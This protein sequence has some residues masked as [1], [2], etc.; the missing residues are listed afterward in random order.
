[1]PCRMDTCSLTKISFQPHKDL[2][3]QLDENILR[4]LYIALTLWAVLFSDNNN[5]IVLVSQ[6][7]PSQQ[8]LNSSRLNTTVCSYGLYHFL[9]YPQSQK[10]QVF[11]S[12]TK[13]FILF[14]NIYGQ[15]SIT[16]S[17]NHTFRKCEYSFMICKME[18]KQW[19]CWASPSWYQL[20]Q[21]CWRFLVLDFFFQMPLYSLREIFWHSHFILAQDLS[22]WT[23][24]QPFQWCE[25][26]RLSTF[27]PTLSGCFHLE[28][29]LFSLQFTQ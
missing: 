20:N 28:V 9:L 4:S 14:C 12:L 21:I 13:Y 25:V 6:K 16:S 22:A 23:I 29:D 17:M 19:F 2:A 10:M 11:A 8:Q 27:F 26:K 3:S 7:L 18:R 1:M 24:W 15:K 5:I